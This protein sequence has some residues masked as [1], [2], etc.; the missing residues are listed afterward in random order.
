MKFD[1]R[2]S[3]GGFRLCRRAAS[4]HATGQIRNV[5]RIV[6]AGGFNHDWR[7][8]DNTST[9]TGRALCLLPAAR[10][11]IATTVES[12]T[13]ANPLSPG[14]RQGGRVFEPT[15]D[16]EQADR[17]GVGAATVR[18]DGEIHHGTT[19][20]HGRNGSHPASLHQ[21]ERAAPHLQGLCAGQFWRPT[22]SRTFALPH[23]SRRAV[24]TQYDDLASHDLRRPAEHR[25]ACRHGNFL[26]TIGV[27]G[28]H[29]SSNP[30]A[31]VLGP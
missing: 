30:A 26:R 29:S 4:G 9:R 18:R 11:P 25:E 6:L 14:N 5:R 16:L 12:Y 8:I 1:R 2:L 22:S 27:I 7:S 20:G 23:D 19:L 15:A 21:E 3:N 17:L 13:L 31:E 10:L 24:Q 28:D